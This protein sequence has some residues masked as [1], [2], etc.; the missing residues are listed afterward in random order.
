[1]EN[2]G[3][4]GGGGKNGIYGTISG[5]LYY[6][7]ITG[8]NKC[9][10]IMAD[11]ATG[12]QW[13]EFYLGNKRLPP[14]FDRE[15]ASPEISTPFCLGLSAIEGIVGKVGLG[16]YAK[17]SSASRMLVLVISRLF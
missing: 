16:I 8:S 11:V 17:N 12:K 3:G 10:Y 2:G 4:G 15:H 5:P 1:M 7:L 13:R 9:V 6:I 14:H